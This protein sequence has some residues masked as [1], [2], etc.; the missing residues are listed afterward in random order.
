MIEEQATVVAVD[1]DR[2]TVTSKIKSACSG[3]QQVDNCGSGQVAKA[4]PQKN[5]S[6]TLKSSLALKP[7]DTVVIG[8]QESA[9]LQ[10]AWQVY[11]WPLIGLIL[12]SGISQ[13]LVINAIFSHEAFALLFG[14]LGGVAGFLLAKRQQISSANC[15]KLAPKIVRLESQSITIAEIND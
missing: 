15:A 10:A 6:L 9:M 5:L 1:H 7:G 13:W 4:F 8:L 14:G 11:I 12:A 3:C 2:V